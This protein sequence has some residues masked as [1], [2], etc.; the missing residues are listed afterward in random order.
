MKRILFALGVGAT[1]FAVAAFAANALTVN[2]G[3]IQSGSDGTVT[4]DNAVNVTYNDIGN[5][6]TFDLAVVSDID[7]PCGPNVDVTVTVIDLTAPATVAFGSSLCVAPSSGVVTITLA[8]TLDAPV[9]VLAADEVHV[10]IVG[11]TP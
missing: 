8:D 9:E 3:P 2:S 5:N 4:C 1:L 6:G 7:G 10:D 11:C